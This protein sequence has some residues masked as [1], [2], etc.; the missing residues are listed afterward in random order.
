[1]RRAGGPFSV[2]RPGGWPWGAVDSGAG[3]AGY[4]PD[5]LAAVLEGPEVL[6]EGYEAEKVLPKIRCPVLILQVDP[7][8]G[9]LLDAEDPSVALRVLP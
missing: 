2:R 8:A 7:A 6:L 5:M 4:D 1:M 9:G 3:T